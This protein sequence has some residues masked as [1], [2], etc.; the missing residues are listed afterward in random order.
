MSRELDLSDPR[1]LEPWMD[2]TL[3]GGGPPAGVVVCLGTTTAGKPVLGFAPEDREGFLAHLG[4]A[5]N[6]FSESVRAVRE[7]GHVIVIVPPGDTEEG[8]LVR[9][10][11]RQMARTCVA[12][13][14]FLPV[15]KKAKVSL[16]S[17]A[18]AQEGKALHQRVIDILSGVD[19]PAIEPIPVGHPR[20]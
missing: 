14:H 20:P 9:A 13:Q 7:N 11:A 3:L 8:H 18:G 15:G 12:E 5:L 1:L 19:P 16:I 6:T 10:A 4:K 17:A 2:N